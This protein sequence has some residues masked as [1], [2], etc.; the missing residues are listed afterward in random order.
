MR[1][2]TGIVER[3]VADSVDG[4]FDIDGTI[5]VKE[6]TVSMVGV[7]AKADIACD[8]EIRV[9]AAQGFDSLDDRTFGIVRWGTA[10]I[11]QERIRINGCM[12]LIWNSVP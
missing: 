7:F 10:F 4:G 3:Y 5:L 1:T 12:N 11:L 8:V 6:A 2:C 9:K